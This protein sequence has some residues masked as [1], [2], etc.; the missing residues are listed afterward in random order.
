MTILDTLGKI[1]HILEINFI[2]SNVATRKFEVTYLLTLC[3]YSPD[4]RLLVQGSPLKPKALSRFRDTQI[5]SGSCVQTCTYAC[6]Y[7]HTIPLVQDHSHSARPVHSPLTAQ[8]HSGKRA[9]KGT[10]SPRP[11]YRAPP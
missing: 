11:A 4:P 9:P 8:S 7:T 2:F 10:R 3:F 6:V 1:K 5:P